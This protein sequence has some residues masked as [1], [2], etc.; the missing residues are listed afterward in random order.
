VTTDAPGRPTARRVD[1]SMSLLVDMMAN[2]LD[3][4]YAEAAQARG[5]GP[6]APGPDRGP[7]RRSVRLGPLAGL[8][9]VGLL[10]GTAVGEVRDRSAESSGLRSGLAD[11]V[12]ARTGQGDALAAQAAA[13]RD[14]VAQLQEQA[15]GSDAAGRAAARDLEVLGAASATTAVRGPGLVVRL[16]DAPQD[17]LPADPLRGGTVPEGRV[18][19]QDLQDVVNG[20]WAAGAEAVAVNRQRLTTL[21]AIRSAGESVLVDLRPLS[22]PYTVEAVGDPAALEVG[23]VAGPSGSRL[24]TLTSL[25]GIVV[26]VSRSDELVL[27]GSGD[28]VLRNALPVAGPVPSGPP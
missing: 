7:R 2:T 27:R 19:D 8:L 15:L 13:L 6:A 18:R 12:A 25:Y 23:F 1:G 10:T 20:L 9:A 24:T 21:S 16:D 5:T 17:A 3:E 11:E 22:P 14:E 26:D 4:A 28:P